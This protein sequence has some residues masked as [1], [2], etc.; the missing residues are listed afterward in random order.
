MWTSP[1]AFRP[2]LIRLATRPA[3]TGI[4]LSVPTHLKTEEGLS[5]YCV[6]Y[7]AAITT[8]RHHGDAPSRSG[9][10]EPCSL[11]V[12]GLNTKAGCSS[13]GISPMRFNLWVPEW[14]LTP[15]MPAPSGEQYILILALVSV[16][17]RPPRPQDRLCVSPIRPKPGCSGL[18]PPNHSLLAP[19][20]APA[21]FPTPPPISYL[22]LKA[23]ATT[24]RQ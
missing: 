7:P 20:G 19:N 24:R 13:M 9:P 11:A 3:A 21:L 5:N 8:C 23:R 2:L 22:G 12:S 1:V 15:V 6:D 17:V 4:S 14:L 18:G 16:L 10:R